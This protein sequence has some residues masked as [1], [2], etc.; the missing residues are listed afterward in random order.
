[1]LNF[2][3]NTVQ[4][5]RGGIIN[6]INCKL[7]VLMAQKQLKITRISNDTGISRTTLTAL[8]QNESKGIQFDTLNILCQYLECN[9]GD[10]FEY[11]PFDV[12]PVVSLENEPVIKKSGDDTNT[13]HIDTTIK[14]L[15][16]DLLLYKNQTSEFSG[17]IKKVFELE[18]R[19]NNE[20]TFYGNDPNEISFITLLG[21]SDSKNSFE[22]QINDF[23][24]FWT[25]ELTPSFQQELKKKIMDKCLATFKEEIESKINEYSKL[26]I[27]TFKF[28]FPFDNAYSTDD[29][30]HPTIELFCQS[31][32]WD[33]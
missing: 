32:P 21:Q 15:E 1:M 8:K 5:Y 33:L 23:K 31:I 24:K 14:D 16:F 27:S 9:P 30:S 28:S 11:L 3:Q 17:T 18:I 10:F 26:N 12:T 22:K 20:T 4:L 7:G 29:F 13:V 25:E 19:L 6:M 2:V